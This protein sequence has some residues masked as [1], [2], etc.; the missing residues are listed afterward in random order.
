MDENRPRLRADKDREV[1]WSVAAQAIVMCTEVPVLL[2]KTDYFRRCAPNFPGSKRI[3]LRNP[4]FAQAL[5]DHPW[6]P[7][8]RMRRTRPIVARCASAKN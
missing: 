6:S 5:G 4:C 8:R 3:A 2:G 7:V 1:Y